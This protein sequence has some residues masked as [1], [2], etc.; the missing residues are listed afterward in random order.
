MGDVMLFGVL[1]MPYDMAMADEYT[2]YQY[3]QRGLQA[4]DAIEALQAENARL[5]KLDVEYGRVETAI[6]MAD[7]HF[8]G[9]SDHANC[10]DRLIASVQRMKAQLAEARDK[11]LED[12]AQCCEREA[13]RCDDAA[14]WGGSRTYVNNCKAAAYAMRDRANAIRAMKGEGGK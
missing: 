13:D 9:D 4:A 5:R 8:D 12:A 2:R 1:R 6:I 7:P 11:A 14:I 3:H 10:A